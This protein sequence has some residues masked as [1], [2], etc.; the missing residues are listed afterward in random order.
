MTKEHN[1]SKFEISLILSNVLLSLV[2]L[3]TAHPH[4]GV[5]QAL[6]AHLEP[7]TLRQLLQGSAIVLPAKSILDLIVATAKVLQENS[8]EG[9]ES[10]QPAALVIAFPTIVMQILHIAA[11][12]QIKIEEYLPK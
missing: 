10:K 9:Y 8:T 1:I 2:F 3:A 5:A 7:E 12:N 11:I 4:S 6:V